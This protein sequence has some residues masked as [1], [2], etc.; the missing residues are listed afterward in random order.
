MILVYM[1]TKKIIELK[2]IKSTNKI[3]L[4]NFNSLK[5]NEIDEINWCYTRLLYPGLYDNF[6]EFLDMCKVNL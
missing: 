2:E 6:E 1:L 4:I 3:H 5:N